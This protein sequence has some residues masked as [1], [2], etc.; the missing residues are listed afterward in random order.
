M[1]PAFA[2]IAIADN[3]GKVSDKALHVTARGPQQPCMASCVTRDASLST[4]T[5]HK[6]FLGLSRPWGHKG[7]IGGSQSSDGGSCGRR[8]AGRR[9][10]APR[11]P[12]PSKAPVR[13][14]SQELDV[15]RTLPSGAFSQTSVADCLHGFGG[16]DGFLASQITLRRREASLFSICK[17]RRKSLPRSIT[18]PV[19]RCPIP[20]LDLRRS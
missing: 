11:A 13:T 6:V 14:P 19:W 12:N 2:D 15:T 1:A 16:G 10:C 18:S 9:H 3:L 20:F 8:A 4:L 5:R 7:S 17:T